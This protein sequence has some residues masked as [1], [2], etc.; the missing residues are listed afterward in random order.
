[1]AKQQKNPKE[2]PKLTKTEI[3]AALDAA[4]AANEAAIA[5]YNAAPSDATYDARQ[6]ASWAL[7][8][9]YVPARDA[10]LVL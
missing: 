8:K 7:K 4:H 5:A 6:M 2:K 9:A 3:L 1:M 10:G